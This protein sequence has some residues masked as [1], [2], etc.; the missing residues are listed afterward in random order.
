[1]TLFKGERG[2]ENCRIIV[3]S[4]THGGFHALYEIVQRH[5]QEAFCFIHLGDGYQEIDE[6]RE[7][8]PAIKLY[9]VCGNCD[10]VFSVPGTAELNVAGKRIFYT[11]GHLYGIK[12]GLERIIAAAKN[13]D[14]DIALYGH[15]HQGYTG[16]EDGLYIMNP[17]SPVRPRNSKA[18]Y[19]VIDITKAG[20]AMHLV[21]V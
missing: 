2:L 14:A 3:V 20:I 16:Y 15:S 19:G 11:H 6:I 9:S 13:I 5:L 21:E 1:M 18:S 17:G 10:F 12:A 7:L 8:Y 4:D